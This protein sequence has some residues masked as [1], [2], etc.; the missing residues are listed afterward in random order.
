MKYTIMY[1]AYNTYSD[2][3]PAVSLINKPYKYM[4]IIIAKKH[5]LQTIFFYPQ[6]GPYL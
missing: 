5:A 4:K 1:V 3:V 2:Y 6:W